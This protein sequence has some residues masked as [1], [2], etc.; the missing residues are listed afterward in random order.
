MPEAF[1]D[2]AFELNGTVA[3]VLVKEGDLV[4]AGDVIAR[5]DTRD[6]ELIVKQRAADLAMARAAYESLLAGATQ[7]E[8]D[9]SAARLANAQANLAQREADIARFQADVAQAQG[10]LLSRQ[11]DVTTA[12]IAAA[13]A[14]LNEAQA[15]LADLLDGEDAVRIQTAQAAVDEA[16]ARLNETL[17]GAKPEDVRLAQARLEEAQ[18]RLEADRN[19]LSADRPAPKPRWRFAPTSCVI[20]KMST[21]ASTGTFVRSSAK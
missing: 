6:L 5:L 1:V 14:E 4:Q 21:A 7:E 10:N 13:E 9:A 19:R 3:E 2:I 8:I 20:A 17:A 15:A 18:V 12:D 11:G 16:R